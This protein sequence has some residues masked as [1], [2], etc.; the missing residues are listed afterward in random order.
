MYRYIKLNLNSNP[1]SLNINKKPQKTTPISL[2]SGGNSFFVKVKSNQIATNYNDKNNKLKPNVYQKINNTYFP[3]ENKNKDKSLNKYLN[4]S[5]PKVSF[6][7]S[8]NNT[9]NQ[10]KINNINNNNNRSLINKTKQEI[11][12]H[13]RGIYSFTSNKINDK[14]NNKSINSSSLRNNYNEVLVTDFDHVKINMNK[15]SSIREKSKE[16]KKPI[17]EKN[18]NNNINYN[19][20]INQTKTLNTRSK[21]NNKI[22]AESLIKNGQKTQEKN[23]IL[24]A[25]SKNNNQI[26]LIRKNQNITKNNNKNVIRYK[27]ISNILFNTNP[28][29]EKNKSKN[30]DNNNNSEGKNRVIFQGQK[31]TNKIINYNYSNNDENNTFMNLLKDNI[32]EINEC[33]SGS[34]SKRKKEKKIKAMN[35]KPNNESFKIQNKYNF[36]TTIHDKSLLLQKKNHENNININQHISTKSNNIINKNPKYENIIPD[37]KINF[38]PE[39]TNIKDLNSKNVIKNGNTS[40]I[41][42]NINSMKKSI[43]LNNPKENKCRNKNHIS[44]LNSFNM[45]NHRLNSNY[46]NIIINNNYLYN[47][48]PFVTLN[49]STIDENSN[50]LKL[51]RNS[52]Y[53]KNYHINT[54]KN[55]PVDKF[56]NYSTI[57]DTKKNKENKNR[58]NKK[59]RIDTKKL[60]VNLIDADS[61]NNK[62]I[63]NAYNFHTKFISSNNLENNNNIN[64]SKINRTNLNL[65]FYKDNNNNHNNITDNYIS[66]EKN[67]RRKQNPPLNKNPKKLNILS[68]IQENNRKIKINIRGKN[69][70]S[71]YINNNKSYN[72][73]NNSKNDYTTIE[74]ILYP[75]N[76]KVNYSIEKF[77]NFDDINTIV[78]RINFESVDLKKNNI[79]TVDNKYTEKNLTNNTLYEQ[80]SEK[81]NV[82]FDKKFE[83]NKQNMSAAQNK[84]KKTNYIYHSKQSG[85][86]KASNKENSSS[87][88][89]IR[90][91]SYIDKRLDNSGI[92]NVN[93][94]I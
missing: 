68:L 10:R 64:K 75:E 26:K 19:N 47:Y 80:F 63:K 9:V 92:I 21:L 35:V 50:R 79:F 62:S 87:V 78:K 61:Q 34:I 14:I 93:K 23:S 49:N 45:D 72:N 27:N 16:T 53:D 3:K 46:P 31:K 84:I 4:N 20:K 6:L 67:K 83:N 44:G 51:N 17:K 58:L 24:T 55:L 38:N 42:D 32:K 28:N 65:Y 60:R 5:Q 59:N 41:N 70:I 15:I 43:E 73:N 89:K 85:S 12:T 1:N 86:T 90:V 88:K 7:F 56:L 48:M 40:L 37:Y 25:L 52:F 22:V 66:K 74:Q 77:D 30:N 81:F 54:T 33:N 39:I 2:I 11:Y 82:I 36:N 18:V 13:N 29:I 57:V 71:T 91:S 8:I 69:N 94:K 76:D